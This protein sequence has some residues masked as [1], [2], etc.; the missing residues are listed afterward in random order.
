[1]T[2]WLNVSEAER[3]RAGEVEALARA[4]AVGAL[5]ER[6][7]DPSWTVRRAVGAALA[8]LGDAAIEPLCNVLRH[9]RSDEARLAAAVDALVACVGRVDETVLGLTNSSDVALVCD[10][11]QILGRR[12]YTKALARLAVLAAAEDDNVALA[13][14]E[15]VGRIGGD[16]AIDVLVAAVESR[17]FFR[18]F[19][20]IDV[21]GRTGDPRAVAPL[22]DLL[23]HPHYAIEAARAL[24]HAAQPNA[25]PALA[26]LLLKPNDAQVRTVAA[27]LVEIHDRS[28]ERFGPSSTVREAMLMVDAS[29]ASRRLT[30]SLVGA[31]E[32]ERTAICRVLGWLGG[33]NATTALVEML[34][35]EPA[36]AM[37]AAV[38]IAS[39]GQ[40]AQPF[41]LAALRDSSSER[42]LLL[43]P[44]LARSATATPDVLECLNDAHPGV[45]SLA[46]DTLGKIG[47]L[48]AVPTLFERLG[49][50]DARVSQAAVSAIQS[51][52]GIESERLA[53]ESAR[54]S[55][56]RVRRSA[57]RIL[58][59]FGWA[60]G[61]EV[62]L[63]G[64]GD[65]DERLR[66]VAAI[67]LASMEDSR[68]V[69]SLISA[70]SHASART[71]SAAVRA[72][73][74]ITNVPQVN[75]CL[76]RSLADDDAWVRY[77]ACQSLSRLQDELSTDAI[78]A[79][80][81][82]DA[83]HVR[84]AA[85]EALARLRGGRAL[86]A[87]HAAADSSD[88]DLQRAALLGIGAVKDPSSV[89]VVRRALGSSDGATR[90][91][92]LSALAEFGG[93]AALSGLR[94]ALSDADES[95][96]NAAIALLASLRGVAA[97]QALLGVIEDP[98]LHERAL[99]AL[100]TPVEGR[101]EGLVAALR[102]ASPDLAPHIV[103]ALARMRRSDSS[104]ALEHAFRVAGAP[105]RR[106]IAPALAALGLPSAR[107][108][109]ERAAQADDDPQVR[110]VCAALLSG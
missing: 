40:E 3:T 81:K 22:C 30:Q 14:F 37:A 59:Y 41:L 108:L 101:V 44:I 73:G 33:M 104:A 13:A 20:A 107:T 71:R 92:A 55:D 38:A 34:D 48:A 84:V 6:L 87:L 88:P 86:E 102:T 2:P 46:C 29:A 69:T 19:P 43:L 4:G 76:R 15:A 68:A 63:E 28:A 35:A 98:A 32:A 17:N 105:T 67:G 60:S 49:D 7:R 99:A 100:A 52:G 110:H 95:V 96:R 74:Q 90:L 85:I 61:L 82:D 47:D 21:L 94:D 93:R 75:E 79:L 31:D 57:L 25:V 5:V 8:R 70:A 109:L 36:A 97:T 50:T 89:S 65:S 80:L 42:R 12:K 91:V 77:Y 72:L 83:G 53:L 23:S 56:L 45:R 26:A 51:L 39:L 62:F 64:I 9:E 11:A 58:S 10:A 106:A 18:A 27:S 78:G 66:D 24:G 1:M 103:S 16:A 54:S